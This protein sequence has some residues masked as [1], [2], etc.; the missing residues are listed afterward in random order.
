MKPSKMRKNGWI[1]A[2]C[3]ILLLAA[4]VPAGTP[5]NADDTPMAAKDKA[6][7]CNIAGLAGTLQ[8]AEEVIGTNIH[9]IQGDTIGEVEE[10]ILDA[11]RRTVEYVVIEADG[12]LY[13]VPWTALGK[14]TESYTLDIT[15][16]RLSGAPTVSSLQPGQFIRPDLRQQSHDFYSA[17]ITAVQ[18]K[19]IGEKAA[20]W[21]KDTAESLTG[22]PQPVLHSTN[23]IL[24]YDVQDAQG[25]TLGELDDVVFD[26]RQGNLAYGLI[27]FGGILGIGQKTAAVPWEAVDIRTSQQIVRLHGSEQTLQA[28][29][30]KDGD[31]QWLSEPAFAQQ[32]HT[33]FDQ[34]PYWEV[35][36]FVPPAGTPS[37]AP[38]GTST[39]W[40]TDSAYNR[41]FDPAAIEMIVGTVKKVDSFTPEKGAQAGLKLK[42]ETEQGRT[43]T[44]YAGPRQHYLRQ[45][46]R[47]RKGDQ[48]AVTGAKASIDGKNVVLASQINKG[49]E[50]FQIRDSQ[51]KPAWQMEKNQQQ[52]PVEQETPSK[53]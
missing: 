13:P 44:V 30:L 14:G 8:S 42:I 38:A 49:Q 22:Q 47:F 21:V 7:E 48:V 41:N 29:V 24:G 43:E 12:K 36:G 3:F 32:V 35:F 23:S 1:L 2:A 40:Q 34:E 4:S 19:N 11:S 10:L 27:T 31:I 39:A 18:D 26:V 6:H 45:E 17:Q 46:V 25:T 5:D 15:S 28:S 53:E 16:D 51:G 37:T 50:T 20:D 52:M 33:E 9:N